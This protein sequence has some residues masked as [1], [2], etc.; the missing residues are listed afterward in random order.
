MNGSVFDATRGMAMRIET[1][2]LAALALVMTG[3]A[4]SS[5]MQLDANT[6]E[7]S[8]S[9]APA[10]GSQGAQRVAVKNAAIETLRRGYDR[11]VILGAQAENNVGVVGHTPLTAN[12][13]GSGTINTYSNQA[14]YNGQSNTYY[15]GGQPIIAG[16]HDQKL[17]VRMFKGDDPQAANAVDARQVLGPEW[18]KAVTKGAG[19]T[20]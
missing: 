11:Y 15:S 1:F 9:A 5:V 8:T 14:T 18:Q 7:I 16:T 6:V 2:A 17:A 10:C 4:S 12:T 13:Y 20:C 19:A 3:C